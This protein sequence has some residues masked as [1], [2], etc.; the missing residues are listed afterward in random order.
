MRLGYDPKVDYAFKKLFGNEEN[1]SL[2]ISLLNAVVPSPRPVTA[3]Q[4]VLPQTDKA[5]PEEKLVVADVKARD[6]G[7][8]QF[9]LEMQWQVPWFFSKRM[10]FYW[11]KFHPQQLQE[12]ENY[13]TLRP[14]I[15][16][17][18]TNRTIFTELDEHHLV[19]RLHEEKHGVIFSDDLEIHLIELPKFTKTVEQLTS[20]LDR[21]CYFVR[22][23]EDPDL[24]QLPAS[25]DVPEIRR[26]LE[27]LTVFTQ[28]ERERELYELRLMAQRDQSSL[29]QDAKEEGALMGQVRMCQEWLKQ[30]QTSLTELA[31]MPREALAA[32]LAELRTQLARN[33]H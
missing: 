30:P 24:D 6:Q 18:F 8:R 12:G 23:G 1:V 19:F 5:S 22:H 20:A 27:V 25:L 15:S 7:N 11:S 2:L 10:L 32:L 4:I 29:L 16:I 28:D 14:T 3:I 13:L 17:C 26:A 21:W 31:A 33:G 9:H